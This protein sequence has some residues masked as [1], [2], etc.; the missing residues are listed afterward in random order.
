MIFFDI[1]CYVNSIH[2]FLLYKMFLIDL[3]NYQN[4]GR[5]CRRR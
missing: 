4:Y 3:Q 2:Q 5:I 1:V